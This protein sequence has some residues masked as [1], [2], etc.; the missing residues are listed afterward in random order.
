MKLR[1]GVISRRLMSTPKKYYSS[2]YRSDLDCPD[3]AIINTQCL[4]IERMQWVII[5]MMQLPIN[6][7]EATT[8]HKLS[9]VIIQWTDW[10][11]LFTVFMDKWKNEFK[12][13]YNLINDPKQIPHLAEELNIDP[14]N[15]KNSTNCTLCKW[16]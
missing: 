16:N 12:R 11:P 14:L 6:L 9:G 7:N 10:I 5:V 2:F 13:K 8:A 15:Y 1:N 4:K 3:K